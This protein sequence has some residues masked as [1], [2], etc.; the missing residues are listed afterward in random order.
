MAK[1][2]PTITGRITESVSD[3]RVTL[4]AGQSCG[5]RSVC[6]KPRTRKQTV[7]RAP[8]R[9]RVSVVTEDRQICPRDRFSKTAW[10]A[11]RLDTRPSISRPKRGGWISR[12]SRSFART[13]TVLTY[14][15][16]GKGGYLAIVLFGGREHVTTVSVH[17]GKSSK[18]VPRACF[19]SF[20]SLS[21]FR[22]IDIIVRNNRVLI[23]MISRA[24]LSLDFN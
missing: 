16:N 10:S 3:L 4:F 11:S 1:V 19:F 23:R 8:L 20:L 5:A 13:K 2:E 21:L 17:G 9:S 12:R 6:S 22:L 24:L 18:F 14:D 15:T 7:L